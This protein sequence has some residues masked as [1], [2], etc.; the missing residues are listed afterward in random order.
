MLQLTP[1]EARAVA[2]EAFV[3]GC[4]LVLMDATRTAFLRAL[5]PNGCRARV[6][7]L[8]HAWA[9]PDASFRRA[10]GADVDTLCS[11]A[12]LDLSA[13]PVVLDVPASAGRYHLL[14]MLSGWTDV[15][16]APGSRTAGDG[17]GAYAV[18]GPEWRGELP[19]GVRE[20][21]SPTSMAW[22]LGRTQTS[23]GRDYELAHRFQGDLALTPLSA[24][25]HVSQPAPRAADFDGDCGAAPLERIAEMDAAAFFGRLARLLVAN[26]PA[27][28]DEPALE[29]FATIGLAPGAFEPA[30]ELAGAL[31]EGVRAGLAELRALR[32]AAAANGWATARDPGRYGTDYRRR[33]CAALSG[34]GASLPED[35]VAPRTAVDGA[36]RPLDGAHRYALHFEAGRTPPS[37]AFWSLTMYDAQGHLVANRL[38]RHAVGGRDRLALDEDG[39]LD[40]W[41]Q[42]DPPGPDREPNWLPA[43]S[44]R[45]HLVLRIYWPKRSVAD[46]TWS[47]PA[48]TRLA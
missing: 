38:D 41:L 33:A 31:D 16:A 22:L 28:A 30:H 15:F 10:P 43:P 17:E 32:P 48:V 46:G 45:F 29:R 18:V 40:I 6:N 25:G 24:W 14:P 47:P 4:P 34:L 2:A 26:P 13:E 5:R 27:D 20:I 37:R 3:F 7:E 23:G 36:G 19:A 44:G 39:S 9:F 21:R 12:W 1:E 35:L 8:A 11:T 42:H